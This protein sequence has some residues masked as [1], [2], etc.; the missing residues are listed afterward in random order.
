MH[1][2]ILGGERQMWI[3]LPARHTASDVPCT[4]LLLL[5]GFIYT[6][7]IPTPTILDNLIAAGR[8][9]PTIAVMVNNPSM[10]ARIRELSCHAPFVDFLAEEL[11]PWVRQAYPVTTDLRR[12]IVGGSSLGGLSA[13]FAAL[14]RP[15]LFG[16]VLSQSGSFWWKPSDEAEA[17]WLAREYAAAPLAARRFYLDVGCLESRGQ[18][19]AN[20]SMRDLLQ[21]RGATVH[22]R[23]FGG[24]HTFLCW[25]GTLA[26]GIVSLT[27]TGGPP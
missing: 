20:E 6:H 9:P 17:G 25:Q 8:I 24:G 1:S 2:A 14:R 16:N 21:A 7:V 13:V 19:L 27:T 18:R 22:Y 23:E 4:L 12:T 5:D 10:E 3:Y 15:D 26:D 11:L